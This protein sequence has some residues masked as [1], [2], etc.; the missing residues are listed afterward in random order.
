MRTPR[1]PCTFI[2]II[3]IISQQGCRALVLHMRYTTR[4]PPT[5]KTVV[6]FFRPTDVYKGAVSFSAMKAVP[7][8]MDAVLLKAPAPLCSPASRHR[9]GLADTQ[10]SS[11]HPSLSK[12]SG[13]LSSAAVVFKMGSTES[14][15]S[16]SQ[17]I[18]HFLGVE[19]WR[20]E[21]R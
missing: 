2:L 7:A 1:L 5:P 11:G 6:A 8:N 10:T 3:L 21:Q 12:P 9:H 4:G 19:K 15:K 14:Q 16:L 17:P 20:T 13:F 18:N